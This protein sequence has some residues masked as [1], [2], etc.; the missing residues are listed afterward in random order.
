[1]K[2]IISLSIVL[3][4][5][6][7]LFAVVPVGAAELSG[8]GYV[9]V[10]PGGSDSN[11]GT[12]DKPLLTFHAARDKAR[13]L[14]KSGNYPEGITVYVRE[15]MYSFTE[16]LL[17]TEEDSDVTW[18]NYNDEKVTIT[19]GVSVNGSD[20]TKVT[21]QSVLDRVVEGSAKDKI[22]QLDLKSYGIYD[23][24]E[25]YLPGAYS[26]GGETFEKAGLPMHTRPGAPNSELLFNGQAMTVARYP[27]SG[28]LNIDAVIDPGW[29][30]DYPD[31]RPA[32]DVFTIRIKDD[33]MK[34]WTKAPENSILMFGYWKFDWADQTV[35]LK[36]INVEKKE[37]TSAHPSKFAVDP[38]KRFYVFNL[39]EELDVAGEYYLDYDNCVLYLIPP[40]DIGKADI[41]LSLLDKELVLMKGTKNI[42]FD[43]I[44][45]TATRAAVFQINDGENNRIND[46][47][48]SYTASRCINIKGGKNN[49]VT[50]CHIHDVDGGITLEFGGDIKTLTLDFV[51][52]P[53]KYKLVKTYL[54][55]AMARLKL[56]DTASSANIRSYFYKEFDNSLAT[57]PASHVNSKIT[58]VH[59]D[60]TTRTLGADNYV[61]TYALTK[62]WQSMYAVFSSDTV[63]DDAEKQQNET[64]YVFNG[65][66]PVDGTQ[67]AV[68]DGFYM[69]EL[70]VCDVEL[71]DTDDSIA[72]KIELPKESA[73]IE[74]KAIMYNQLGNRAGLG[75]TEATVSSWNVQGNPMGIS[76]DD[77]VVTVTSEASLG[78]YYIEAEVETG[79]AGTEQTKAKGVYT[80]TI[81]EPVDRSGAQL[82]DIILGN[83][84]VPN[85]HPKKYDY[86]VYIPYRYEPN[87]FDVENVLTPE[88][89]VIKK[90]EGSVVNI[91]RPEKADGNEIVIKVTSEDGQMEAT[92][93]LSMEVVGEN[94]YE[95]G[96]F[97][98]AGT[99]PDTDARMTRIQDNPASGEWA[100][101]VDQRKS[102]FYYSATRPPRLNKNYTYI[103]QGM[104]RGI[105]G[106]DSHKTYNNFNGVSATDDPKTANISYFNELG[107]TQNSFQTSDGWQ[108]AFAVIT[109]LIDYNLSNHFTTWGKQNPIVIDEYFVGELVVSAMTYKGENTGIIPASGD[110][111]TA[112]K[113]DATMVNQFGTEIGLDKA[114]IKYELVEAV[115]GVT[116]EGNK[117]YVSDDA[118]TGTFRIRAYYEPKYGGTQGKAAITSDITLTPAGN[119]SLLPQAKNVTLTGE[120][121]EDEVLVG[122]YDYYQ[123]NDEDEGES[124]Y[125]WYSENLDGTGRTEITSNAGKLEF[126]VTSDYL[127]KR[128]C[129][130]VTPVMADGTVGPKSISDYICKP[131]APYAINVKV[132]GDRCVGG[133]L[134]GNY[135]Y[136]DPNSDA[137]D[138]SGTSF[139]WLRSADGITDFKAIDDAAADTYVITEDDIGKYIVFSVKPMA[140]IEPAVDPDKS[141][142]SD[143]ILAAAA[144][145]VSNVAITKVSGGTYKVTY[146][147][148]HPTGVSE[149][150]TKVVWQVNGSTSDT[151]NKTITVDTGKTTELKVT[152][153][154]YA[155]KAPFEGKS[156]SDS[157]KIESSGK[158]SV[159]VSKGSGGGGSVFV[160]LPEVKVE[161]PVV[162]APKHWAEDGIAFCKANGIMQD[163]AQGDFGNTQIVTRAELVT[164]I[165]KT[166]GEKDSAYAHR[167][168][169]VKSTDHFAGSLQK[170]VDLGIISEADNFEPYRNVT[171]QEVAKIFVAAFGQDITT[172]ADLTKFAD[173]ALISDWAQDWVSK[174]VSKG[175]L[176]GVSDYEFNP[177]GSITR[178]QTAVLLKRLYDLRNG[179]I[180]E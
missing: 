22:Y 164:Y 156:V 59:A 19:G 107:G 166:L 9:Y 142:E 31:A 113:L 146:D 123:I 40:G 8:H 114:L 100:M 147:Y 76:V 162:E 83:L 99:W 163:V 148:S 43:G 2:R 47:E 78:T 129:F 79:I 32:S 130:E 80:L 82:A 21:D 6:L 3:T 73:Q 23:V 126:T 38:N 33:R 135:E 112:V 124:I 167:F 34:Y 110:A 128:I 14:K 27:N 45:A 54:S 62:E 157:I 51:G 53:D 56:D 169:D 89:T 49:G 175:I 70:V 4:I 65:F 132:T 55:S 5:V 15:G 18:T 95:D 125:K 104:V 149:G 159:K 85:F 158:G 35:P 116:I 143:P 136:V 144:P 97:E 180:V 24:G 20:F 154:P 1:M 92:Y 152:V 161:E 58:H 48:I 7:S 172:K 42:L 75:S 120:V 117:L 137:E 105:P 81:G 29:N 134:K 145:A 111:D 131:M 30:R 141:Y 98:K 25:P 12:L 119:A 174:S 46:S 66:R 63:L 68:F 26:Y 41:K 155:S 28:W 108:K 86:T 168:Y 69:G 139:A 93:T 10:A 91:D 140:V 87:N 37:L 61:G 84:S 36:S 179:G 150:D 13:Q 176:K 102:A 178:E 122:D 60:G 153:T 170:A 88:V 90:H 74:L 127:E 171:R 173:N 16:Q 72:S 160:P 103:T 52:N 109:P 121:I 106:E 57:S 138:V 64:Y 39:I 165:I 115:D 17:L 71:S 177:L 67:Y 133:T 94:M 151:T 44:D 101:Y 118:K 77:G 50:N 96:G 11:P